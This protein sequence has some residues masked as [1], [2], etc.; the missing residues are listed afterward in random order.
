MGFDILALVAIVVLAPFA[1]YGAWAL[2]TRRRAPVAGVPAD[3]PR[4]SA[5]PWASLPLA[6][7]GFDLEDRLI[8]ASRAFRDELGARGIAL[9]DV[10]RPGI[11]AQALF[12]AWARRSGGAIAPV[13]AIATL[14]AHELTWPAN[15]ARAPHRLACVALHDA[16]GATYRLLVDPAILSAAPIIQTP[17]SAADARAITARN[18]VLASA[19]Q[20]ITIGVALCDA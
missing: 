20:S 5:D 9:D 16:A 4:P 11:A 12:D 19:L 7:A 2:W 15:G 6:I 17:D 10:L 3:P 18:A 1:V 14:P 8:G 13:T